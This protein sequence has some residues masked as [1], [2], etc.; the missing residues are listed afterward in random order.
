[1][2][3]S[4]NIGDNLRH[5][6]LKRGL[7]QSQLGAKLPDLGTFVAICNVLKVS[8]SAMLST[9]EKSAGK[10]PIAVE[11]GRRGGEKGGV[12]RAAKLTP[13]E[14]SDIARMGGHARKGSRRKVKPDE[15]QTHL[16]S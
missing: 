16:A 7:S 12:A 8:P 9:G 1:V 13:Q 10:D 15:A 5:N 2:K 6:R 11:L 3:Y 14:R 4:E